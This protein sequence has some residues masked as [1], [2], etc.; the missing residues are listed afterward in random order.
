MLNFSPKNQAQY[1]Y[2]RY[3]YKKHVRGISNLNLTLKILNILVT[4]ILQLRC[5]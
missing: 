4:V 2:K 1:A 5:N 3:T